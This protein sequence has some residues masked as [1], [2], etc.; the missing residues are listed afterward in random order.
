MVHDIDF[1]VTNIQYRR[2]EKHEDAF[3]AIHEFV[4]WY[5]SHT[6][7]AENI[8]IINTFAGGFYE[9]YKLYTDEFG[10]IDEPNKRLFYAKLAFISIYNAVRDKIFD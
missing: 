7:E 1:F 2:N 3:D 4:D 5:V 10:E 8:E 6:S 9:A